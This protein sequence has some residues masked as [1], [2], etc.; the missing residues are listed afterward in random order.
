MTIYS[1]KAGDTQAPTPK[2]GHNSAAFDQQLRED[3]ETVLGDDHETVFHYAQWHIGDYVAGTR[4]MSLEHEGA[5][6][7]FLMRL[8]ERGKPLPDDDR[9][10][11]TCMAL[12]IRVWRRIKQTLIQFGKI[13]SRNGCLTN[14]RF[15]RERQRR[16]DEIRKQAHAARKGWDRK[17]SEEAKKAKTSPKVSESLDEVWSK[18]LK[19]FA[20]K[21]SEI[22]GRWHATRAR[23]N[24][25]YP[26]TI[27]RK[28]PCSPPKG[29]AKKRA[30]QMP[31]G[32]KP[33]P[34]TWEWARGEKIGATNDQIQDQLEHFTD[35][36]R[37]KAL[38]YADWDRAFQTWIRNAK[39]WGRLTVSQRRLAPWE[40]E[41]KEDAEKTKR[42]L[43]ELKAEKQQEQNN[44]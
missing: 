2:A 21:C 40:V 32:W 9:F 18:V 6:I 13:V 8:Y 35:H 41:A 34:Q 4:G 11:A 37:A 1:A 36:A 22:N 24:N 23:S 39:A 30:H 15:E 43:A 16:A 12:S 44:G 42:V 17:R 10:M 33:K 27:K 19:N 7:R 3:V 14:A 29:G 31:E 5:Y 28:P 26:I 25:H 20:E 38:R